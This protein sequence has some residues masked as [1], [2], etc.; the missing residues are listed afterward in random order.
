MAHMTHLEAPSS[1]IVILDPNGRPVS[2]QEFAEAK[3]E[4][5]RRHE[6]SEA[7]KV[8]QKL[9]RRDA[10]RVGFRTIVDLATLGALAY[11]ARQYNSDQRREQETR[12]KELYFQPDPRVQHNLE[13][14]FP[15]IRGRQQDIRYFP[16]ADNQLL[17]EMGIGYGDATIADHLLCHGEGLSVDLAASRLFRSEGGIRIAN[18][19]DVDIFSYT[20]LAQA[21]C[22]NAAIFGKSFSGADLLGQFERV[23]LDFN[24]R[25]VNV[26]VGSPTG[27]NIA[28]LL[29]GKVRRC[30][31]GRRR[32]LKHEGVVGLPLPYEF[33]LDA[34]KDPAL[35][36]SDGKMV[37]SIVKNSP[38]GMPIRSPLRPGGGIDYF[39][40]SVLPNHIVENPA[41]DVLQPVLLFEG[42]TSLGTS[43]IQLLLDSDAI[44]KYG[45][46]TALIGNL[47]P[48]KSPYWQALFKVTSTKP[49]TNLL[50][51]VETVASEI[52]LEGFDW[53]F[54]TQELVQHSW[55][56]RESLRQDLKILQERHRGKLN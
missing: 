32:E 48:A 19:R 41:G 17:K 13:V 27:N 47:R 40:I 10:F 51:N 34:D 29:R 9:S 52:H 38:S 53:V 37:W 22:L 16:N 55:L 31:P 6:S 35:R 36:T 8:E 44:G 7:P 23:R 20:T 49:V 11:A 14:I 18:K 28:A 12:E 1:S 56:V 45:P 39:T 26:I 15:F 3:G 43:G 42:C 54:P 46:L 25:A 24:A 5:V 21:R 33:S 30:E 4:S 2:A 50:S